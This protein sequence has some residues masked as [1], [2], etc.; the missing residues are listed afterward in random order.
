MT[1][2]DE[3]VVEGYGKVF[4]KGVEVDLTFSNLM[5][6]IN[7]GSVK[8]ALEEEVIEIVRNIKLDILLSKS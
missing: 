6:L 7:Q 2:K 3:L 4:Y 1:W 5:N 8:E